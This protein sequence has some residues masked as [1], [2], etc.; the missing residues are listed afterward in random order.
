MAV[1]GTAGGLAVT[2]GTRDLTL[3]GTQSIALR[4]RILVADFP[5]AAIAP[6]AIESA[7]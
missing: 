3:L 6:Y 1:V 2:G 4:D 7:R 5:A